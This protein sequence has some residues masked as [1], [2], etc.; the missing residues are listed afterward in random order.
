[1][2]CFALSLYRGGGSGQE[3][4]VTGLRS[5]ICEAGFGFLGSNQSCPLLAPKEVH[6]NAA[7]LEM[8]FYIVSQLYFHKN[9]E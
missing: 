4:A 5:P 2:V 7:C 8:S 1:M 9:K 3:P 6:S